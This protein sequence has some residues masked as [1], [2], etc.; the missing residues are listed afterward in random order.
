MWKSLE[1]GREKGCTKIFSDAC[2]V[3][4]GGMNM[5]RRSWNLMAERIWGAP[6][7]TRSCG[8]R[9]CRFLSCWGACCSWSSASAEVRPRRQG[10]AAG[11]ENH[12]YEQSKGMTSGAY[13]SVTRMREVVEGNIVHTKILEF[14]YLA[15]W[16]SAVN[17]GIYVF[18]PVT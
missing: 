5:H 16:V 11:K 17:K 7:A 10:G 8:S 9:A 4:V 12:W 6:M 14:P 3:G 13:T 1:T 18:L 2:T 15:P